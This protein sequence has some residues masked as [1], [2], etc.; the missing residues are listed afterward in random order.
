MRSLVENN[1]SD[2]IGAVAKE[3]LCMKS[4]FLL[5]RLLCGHS[6]VREPRRSSTGACSRT[7]EMAQA[8]PGGLLRSALSPT[9]TGRDGAPHL[10]SGF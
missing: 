10:L 3:Q 5:V 9:R 2:R 7:C 8:S 6:N 4:H 1:A